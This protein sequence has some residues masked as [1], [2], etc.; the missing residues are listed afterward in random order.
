MPNQNSLSDRLAQIRDLII[1]SKLER[2][3]ADE[4]ARQNRIA[5]TVEQLARMSG[6]I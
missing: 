3:L 6:A 5:K 4:V 1:Q 2:Q